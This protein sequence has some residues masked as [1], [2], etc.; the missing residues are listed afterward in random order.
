MSKLANMKSIHSIGT[1][2]QI[3]IRPG[4]SLYAPSEQDTTPSPYVSVHEAAMYWHH[5][6]MM[7][8]VWHG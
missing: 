6:E 5:L 4:G 2:R 3:P 7:Y 8:T 1:S